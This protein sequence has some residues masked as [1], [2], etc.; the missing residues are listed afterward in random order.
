MPSTYNLKAVLSAY[1]RLSPTLG[2]INKNLNITRYR[3]RHLAGNAMPLAGAWMAGLSVP[4]MKFAQ[5]E[6][7]ATGLKTAMMVAGGKVGPEF[8][9]I[10]ALAE[11]LGNRLPGNTADFQ[12]MMTVLQRQGMSAKAV[13]GGLGEATAYLGVQLKMPYENAAEFAAKLQD[14]TKT[15]ESDMLGLADTIQRSY[16]LGVDPDNML[17]GFAKISPALDIIRQQGLKAA[18]T[19]APLLVMADQAAMSGEAAGNAYRKIF[20]GALDAGKIGKANA[21]LS[22]FKVH[23]DFTNR[24]GEFAGIENMFTQLDKLRKLNTQTRIGAIKTMFGDDAETLQAVTLLAGKNLA[25]YRGILDRMK[26]QASLQERV[27]VQMG[28]LN[29]LWGATTGTFENALVAIGGAYAPEV[30]QLTVGM[31]DLSER[32]QRYAQ[33][34]PQVIRTA[35]AATGAFVG[36]K[37]A[38][39]AASYGLQAMSRA[40]V[41]SPAGTAV[42]VLAVG[43]ALVAANWERVGPVFEDVWRSIGSGA[44]LN[45]ERW[46][47]DFQR[48]ADRIIQI[49]DNMAEMVIKDLRSF[50]LVLPN[51]MLESTARSLAEIDKRRGEILKRLMEGYPVNPPPALPAPKVPEGAAE[52][53][54]GFKLPAYFNE[55]NYPARMGWPDGVSGSPYQSSGGLS[56]ESRP[57]LLGY[58]RGESGRSEVTID[59]NLNGASPGQQITR[60]ESRDSNPRMRTLPRAKVGYREWGNRT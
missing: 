35:V 60:L 58:Y 29:N 50:S 37:V 59:V 19:F 21:M 33:A 18:N 8:E 43:G 36:L 53:M 24:R 9:R 17:Q 3:L 31:G 5:A 10:A 7:A 13:L 32:F 20:Q 12:N 49:A 6:D 34:N 42:R 11:K 26:D 56:R 51:S 22:R 55:V 48:V 2:K 57:S 25:G 14:A 47:S 28:T 38:A 15:T 4:A 27:N 39:W 46:P 44:R 30:K 23:I 41:L 1:D 40:M 54:K 52:R 45:I 16:Y